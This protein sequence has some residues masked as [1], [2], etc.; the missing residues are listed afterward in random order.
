MPNNVLERF[1]TLKAMNTLVKS[2]NNEEAYYGNWIY[3]VPDE[4][5]DEDLMEIAS[6]DYQEQTFNDAVKCFIG[7]MCHYTLDGFYIGGKVYGGRQ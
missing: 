1:E 6:E 2:L 7:I 4:A 3:I 5:S